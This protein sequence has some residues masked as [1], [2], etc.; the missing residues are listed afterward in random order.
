MADVLDQINNGNP[1]VRAAYEDLLRKVRL[2]GPVIVEAKKTSVHLKARVAFAGVHPRKRYLL[3]QIVAEKG[4]QS[5]RVLKV[6]RISANRVHN[7]VRI[8]SPADLDDEVMDW[9]TEAYLLTA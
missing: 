1:R 2:I 3:L 4:I 5:E 6:D 8:D 7:H 9:L